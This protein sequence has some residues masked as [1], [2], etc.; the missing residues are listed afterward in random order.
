MISAD[1][2]TIVFDYGTSPA[3]L[4]LI[5]RVVF[6]RIA[7]RVAAAGEPWKTFFAPEELSA[8]LHACGFSQV[9]NWGPADLN[10]RYFAGRADGL[11][12]GE[13]MQIAKAGTG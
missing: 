12:I 11:R 9:E 13:M 6:D 7:K 4:S 5:G 8:M 3:T 2:T 10:A 1:G